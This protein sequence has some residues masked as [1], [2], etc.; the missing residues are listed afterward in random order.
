MG[1]QIKT[2][3]QNTTQH[4]TLPNFHIMGCSSSKNKNF[5]HSPKKSRRPAAKRS[6]AKKPKRKV[7]H[8]AKHLKKPLP[9]YS[10][11]NKATKLRQQKKRQVM[12]RNQKPMTRAEKK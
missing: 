8:K 11:K 1:T 10:K 4:H 3:L 6:A 9:Q 5:K 2:K 7:V 12:K